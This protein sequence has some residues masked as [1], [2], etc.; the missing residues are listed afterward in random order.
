MLTLLAAV[1]LSVPR[2]SQAQTPAAPI[3]VEKQLGAGLQNRMITLRSFSK[4][5]HQHFDTDGQPKDQDES[6]S[7]TIHSQIL[8]KKVEVSQ[9]RVRI[10][11]VRVIHHYD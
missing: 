5:A 3:L 8:V 11:G 7:W 4:S 9:T 10:Y 1:V 6:G 2:G